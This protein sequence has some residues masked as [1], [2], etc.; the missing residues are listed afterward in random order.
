MTI[1]VVVADDQPI[2]RAGFSTIL[3]AQ[4]DIDVVG[5]DVWPAP[6]TW[7]VAI[8]NGGKRPPAILS[9][10]TDLQMTPSVSHGM[11]CWISHSCP[12]R[13]HVL[14]A[15]RLPDRPAVADAATRQWTLRS[16][17]RL[18]NRSADGVAY[19][20]QRTEEAAP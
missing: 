14:A 1:R 7:A 6:G 5:E 20:Q 10:K 3:D 4:P 11:S 19:G 18:V 15:P 8:V 13:R 9:P 2:V 17:D 12:M 16:R